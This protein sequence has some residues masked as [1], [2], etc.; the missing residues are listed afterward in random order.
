M[1]TVAM[2]PKSTN[3]DAKKRT[4][5]GPSGPNKRPRGTASQPINIDSQQLSH[6]F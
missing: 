1:I 2:P 6:A 3:K 5:A 4:K